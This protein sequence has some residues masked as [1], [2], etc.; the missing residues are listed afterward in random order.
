MQNIL[1]MTD[2]SIAQQIHA[3]LECMTTEQQKAVLVFLKGMD[4]GRK[5]SSDHACEG[6]NG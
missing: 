5:F 2:L 6:R 3:I 4:L 1:P